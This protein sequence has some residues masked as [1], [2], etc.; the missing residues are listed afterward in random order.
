VGWGLRP[1]RRIQEAADAHRADDAFAALPVDEAPAELRSLIGAFNA[2]LRRLKAT[3]DGVRRFSADASHQ[4]RTP[5]AVMRT[6]IGL[7]DSLVGPSGE[8]R[9]RLTDLDAGAERLQRL[10]EQLLALARAEAAGATRLQ[11]V[12]LAPLVQQIAMDHAPFALRAA[13]DIDFEG[14]A[15]HP[16][17]WADPLFVSE[18]V[19]NLLENAVCYAGPGATI[20]IR[21]ELMDDEVRLVI[22]DD[23]AGASAA[24][25]H[26]LTEP[27]YRAGR[28][29][30]S[31]G[32]GLGLS[33]VQ[34]LANAM[35]GRFEVQPAEAGLRTVTVFRMVRDHQQ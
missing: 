5:V 8:A 31:V 20:T 6:N 34:R 7:L 3:T 33:I 9:E 18:I 24:D 29:R 28:E 32:S 16:K 27:F 17:A 4:L 14:G 23:G 13:Q 2:L 26:R 22:A 21:I 15:S 1:L 35:G 30:D 19:R 12:D 10:I 25:L 11:Q